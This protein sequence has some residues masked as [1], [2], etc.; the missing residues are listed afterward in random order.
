MFKL[1]YQ[2][3]AYL[4]DDGRKTSLAFG[5]KKLTLF[6]GFLGRLRPELRLDRDVLDAPLLD[7]VHHG[8]VHLQKRLKQP[9][10]TSP[11][12]VFHSSN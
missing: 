2:H 3:F 7:Q 8:S 1:M 11:V 9:K 6:V 5:Q 10:I 12:A 4:C